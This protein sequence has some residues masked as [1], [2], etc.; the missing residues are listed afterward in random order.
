MDHSSTAAR[1]VLELNKFS[2]KLH[3]TLVAFQLQFHAHPTVLISIAWK[4]ETLKI[5]I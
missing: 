4:T 5:L 2:K 3:R 1:I